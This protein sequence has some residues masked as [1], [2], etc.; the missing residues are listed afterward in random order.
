M[1]KSL[2]IFLWLAHLIALGALFSQCSFVTK[3]RELVLVASK[4][5]V[6]TR[7]LDAKYTSPKEF[8][9]EIS[10]S[11]YLIQGFA[12]SQNTSTL[13]WNTSTGEK[14][15]CIYK[16][17]G[18]SPLKPPSPTPI[19]QNQA[20]NSP[21]LL[22]EYKLSNCSYGL[23]A[24]SKVATKFLSFRVDTSLNNQ[25]IHQISATIKL[26]LSDAVVASATPTPSPTP[27]VE[28]TVVPTE[29]PVW[30]SQGWSGE[31]PVALVGSTVKDLRVEQSFAEVNSFLFSGTSPIQKNVSNSAI[32]EKMMGILRGVIRSETGSPLA[33]VKVSVLDKP[34]LGETLTREGGVF[35]FALNGEK[36]L[37][38]EFSKSGYLTAQRSLKVP[39]AF[40]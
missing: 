6:P 32:S 3:N 38:F 15:S 23:K 9:F 11:A 27:T 22:M 39:V 16:A 31:T 4:K 5:H 25:K 37:T 8:E 28:P 29:P 10:P 20:Q 7:Y 26:Q 33:G 12:G 36:F 21:P 18:F 14:G 34:E 2:K 13:S 17:V 30:A 1:N 24:G 40:V 19:A 35:D